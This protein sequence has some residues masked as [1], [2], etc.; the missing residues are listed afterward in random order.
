MKVKLQQVQKYRQFTEEFKKE[1]VRDFESGQYSVV[2]LVRLH[3]ISSRSIYSWIYKYSTFNKKGYRVVESK[4]SSIKKV[5][6]LEKKIKD[7][8]AALGRK[9]ITIDY[10]ETM[11]EVAKDELNYDIKKNFNTPPSVNSEK[12]K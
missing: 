7:L 10:L 6:D 4:S 1:I 5:K 8:E 9:Q 11:I 2:E 12:D 3:G